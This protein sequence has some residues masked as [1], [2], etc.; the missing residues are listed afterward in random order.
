MLLEV[1]GCSPDASG[2]SFEGFNSSPDGSRRS[3]DFLEA[4]LKLLVAVLMLPVLQED[5]LMSFPR[6]KE[7]LIC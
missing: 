6:S 5:P 1:V 3:S 7:T 4:F 2:S